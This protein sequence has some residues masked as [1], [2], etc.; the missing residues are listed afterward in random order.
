MHV[1]D[2]LDGEGD[3]I[4]GRITRHAVEFVFRGES[5]MVARQGAPKPRPAQPE[6]VPEGAAAAFGPEAGSDEGR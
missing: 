6:G 3:V 2:E 1:G 5:I 4:V